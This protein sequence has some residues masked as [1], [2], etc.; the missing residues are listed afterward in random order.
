M[1]LM[2]TSK[3]LQYYADANNINSFQDL[4]SSFVMDQLVS[5]LTPDV[6]LFYQN[7]SAMLKHV[8]SNS[9]HQICNANA[10]NP[11][12]FNAIFQAQPER[13]QTRSDDSTP[14][15]QFNRNKQHSLDHSKI[16]VCYFCNSECHKI[17]QCAK[18]LSN[19]KSELCPT[20]ERQRHKKQ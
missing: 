1:H 2:N 11:G 15:K 9:T 8:G 16:G 17:G 13:C 5:S 19:C 3:L 10:T 20:G 4:F 12:E 18:N 6:C 7:N 14:N